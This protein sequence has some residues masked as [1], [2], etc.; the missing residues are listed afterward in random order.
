M[1]RSH[2]A[3]RSVTDRTAIAQRSDGAR[4]LS[5]SRSRSFQMLTK[6]GSDCLRSDGGL[7]LNDGAQ[8]KK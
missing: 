8:K 4:N 2:V 1:S 5:R 3:Q 7:L 6:G